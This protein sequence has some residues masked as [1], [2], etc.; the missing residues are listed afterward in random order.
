MGLGNQ[1]MYGG[2]LRVTR[3][4]GAGYWTCYASVVDDRTN[5]PTYVAPVEVFYP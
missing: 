4:A 2:W 5:D 3:T 1:V